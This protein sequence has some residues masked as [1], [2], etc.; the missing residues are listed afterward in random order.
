MINSQYNNIP[1]FCCHL[2]IINISWCK[3]VVATY[4][5]LL[6]NLL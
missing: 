1:L 3:G 2:L 4:C 5:K 6:V